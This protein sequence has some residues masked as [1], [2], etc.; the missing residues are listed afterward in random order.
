VDCP[1]ETQI[2]RLMARDADSEAQA[3]RIL[4]AQASRGERLAIADDVVSND[5]SLEDTRR[6]V[7]AL[8]EIYRSLA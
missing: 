5:G 3:R 8:H 1:E 4:A 6:Q 7:A 2:E